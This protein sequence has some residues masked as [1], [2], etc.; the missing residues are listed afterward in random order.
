MTSAPALGRPPS[1]L[2]RANLPFAVGAVALVTLGAFENRA[3]TTVLPTVAVDLGGL[4]LF[5]AASAAPLISFVVATTVAGRWADRRGPVQVLYGGMGLFV[6]ADLLMGVAPAMPVFVG[7]RLLGGFAEGL[8]DVG[9]TVLVAQ[10]LAP[11]LRP[12]IFASFAAAWVLPSLL[13]PS[14]AGFVAEQV[15]WRAVFLLGPAL[16]VPV[17]AF[18]RPA[19]SSMQA[20]WRAP[21]TGEAATPDATAR[22]AVWWS[23]VAAAGLAGLTAGAS[24]LV[25]PQPS[26]IVG[27][28][29]VL[30]STAALMPALRAVLP[31]GTLTGAP[32]IPA[33]TALR[34]LLGAAFGTVA[35]LLPLMLTQVHRYGP[36]AAGVSLTITGLFWAAGSNLQSLTAVQRR[37]S[38]VARLRTGF[39]LVTA[40]SLGPALLAVDLVPAWTGLGLWAVAAMGIG[41][42]SPTISTQVLALSSHADQGRNSAAS[43]LAP[44][45]SQALAFAASGS[46]IAWQAPHLTGALFAAVMGGAAVLGA[47][48]VLPAPRAR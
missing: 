12:R 48:G 8:L 4:W 37:T 38:V 25:E 30:A 46:A 35:G 16:L 1:L 34:A 23:V 2:H 36:A 40:G 28:V 33:L 11:E 31:P 29:L 45:V 39:V 41:I 21:M 15:H 6:G 18:L 47:L 5:G 10:A 26:S 32:G 3:V 9:L 42:C 17:W 22:Q 27:A 14:V 20:T 19:M 44:S 7:G 13:G 43:L 24:L